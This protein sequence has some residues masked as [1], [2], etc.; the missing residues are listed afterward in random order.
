[1]WKGR[2]LLGLVLSGAMAANGWALTYTGNISYAD[3]TAQISPAAPSPWDDAVLSWEVT[4]GTGSWTY[5]YTW[6]DPGSL[7]KNVSH[8]SIEVSSNFTAADLLSWEFSSQGGA[9]KALEGPKT[10]DELAGGIYGYKWETEELDGLGIYA[11]TLTLVSTRAP[12][13]GDF[14]LKDGKF[15]DKTTGVEGMVW[16]SNLEFGSDTMAAVANGNADGWVLVPNSKG[17]TGGGDPIP[18]P[19]TMLLLGTG[20]LGIARLGR[21]TA[22]K[23]EG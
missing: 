7:Q 20:L 6:S 2:L 8:F 19:G 21:R 12:M 11:F 9:I 17:G 5:K 13:W 16:F 14:Y 18:E 23:R 1:M 10:H 22:P 15:K 4:A 3:G